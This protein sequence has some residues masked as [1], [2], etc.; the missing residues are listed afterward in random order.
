MGMDANGREWLRMAAID[1]EW[2][3]MAATG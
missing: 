1:C 3:G 2:S